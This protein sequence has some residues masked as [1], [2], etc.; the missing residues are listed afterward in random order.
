M[1]FFTGSGC[2]FKAPHRGF[3]AQPHTSEFAHHHCECVAVCHSCLRTFLWIAAP[4]QTSA[5]LIRVKFGGGF[6]MCVRASLSSR[7]PRENR[8]TPPPHHPSIPLPHLPPPPLGFD[9]PLQPR[10][11]DDR[12]REERAVREGE[13]RERD[14]SFSTSVEDWER[15]C[16]RGGGRE[17]SAILMMSSSPWEEGGGDI[18]SVK[19]CWSWVKRA[20]TRCFLFTHTE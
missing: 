14:D 11:K 3:S 4:A 7:S 19:K 15:V 20:H 18:C 17:E 1:T 13:K 9:P 8:N 5:L 10:W 12:A 2:F 16:E 6:C